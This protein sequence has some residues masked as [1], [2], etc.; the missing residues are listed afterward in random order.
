MWQFRWWELDEAGKRVQRSRLIG[1]VEEFPTA[2]DAQRAVDAVRLEVNAELPQAVP[3]TVGTL[4][5]RYLQDGIE[6]DRLAFSTKMSYKTYL[7]GWI[8]PKWGEH[9]LEHVKT[10]AVEQWFRDLTQAPRTKVH[11]R[12]VMHVLYECAARWELIQINPITRVRQGGSRLAD[13][14]ILT[15]QEF[16]SLVKQIT[17]DRVRTMVMLAGCL[18]LTRSEFTALKWQ[19]FDWK[20]ATLSIQRGIVN[21]HVGNPKTRARR[22]PVPLAAELVAVLD[23]WRGKT[24]YRADSDW[25]F[26]SEFKNGAEPVWPDSLLKR[27]VQPAA[28]RAGISKRVGWHSLRHMYSCLLRANGADIKVQQELV[29]HSTA[30]MTL[31]TYTQAMNEPKRAANAQVVGQLLPVYGEVAASA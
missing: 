21:N 5:D 16:R 18:G 8:R 10:M 15:P 3:V 31:D 23:A 27:V 12:N 1:T 13:P 20:N 26:A 24:A 19:D 14:D 9:R 7:N 4:I 30:A 2:K 11:C 25:L 17:D 29:R 28:K 6:M 22:K